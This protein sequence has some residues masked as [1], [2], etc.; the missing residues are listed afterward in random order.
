MFFMVTKHGSSICS[1]SYKPNYFR[2]FS[3]LTPNCSQNSCET[4]NHFNTFEFMITKKIMS[5]NT[6]SG[7]LLSSFEKK[8]NCNDVLSVSVNN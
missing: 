2:V 4:S 7:T 1:I 6:F 5:L 3:F 8:T